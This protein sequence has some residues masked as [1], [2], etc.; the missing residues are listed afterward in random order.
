MGNC[1]D[2]VSPCP[3]FSIYKTQEI[4]ECCI[5]DIQFQNNLNYLLLK[6]YGQMAKTPESG[7][8]SQ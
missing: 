1:P 8:L 3:S 7:L 2:L 5:R 4:F 6:I